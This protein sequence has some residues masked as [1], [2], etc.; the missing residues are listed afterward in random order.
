MDE[1]LVI[2]GLGAEAGSSLK[3]G[4]LVNPIGGTQG[5]Q[6]EHSRDSLLVHP[7]KPC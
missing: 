7:L 2:T 1:L 5:R 4:A 3:V 6:S